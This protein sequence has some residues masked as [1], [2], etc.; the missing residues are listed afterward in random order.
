LPGG[1]EPVGVD[2]VDAGVAGAGAVDGEG[3]R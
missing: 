3:D 2:P 1:G